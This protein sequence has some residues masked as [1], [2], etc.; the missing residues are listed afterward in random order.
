[1]QV[2]G[3]Q[4]KN[5]WATLAFLL[6]LPLAMWSCENNAAADQATEESTEMA[7]PAVEE[8]A[9]DTTAQ[10]TMQHS[11]HPQ[12]SEHPSSSEHPK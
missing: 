11:E 5:L 9:V 2:I 6:V 12:G 8:A 7:E 1:M 4:K 3:N 10:D